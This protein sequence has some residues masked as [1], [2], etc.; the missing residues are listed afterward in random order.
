VQDAYYEASSQVVT[1]GGA[2]EKAQKFQT[3]KIR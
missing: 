2:N 3:D 1:G